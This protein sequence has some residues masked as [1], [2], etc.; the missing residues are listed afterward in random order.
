MRWEGVL[1][2]NPCEG[3]RYKSHTSRI[4]QHDEVT[5][6][7][8]LKLPDRTTFAGLRD[9]TIILTMLD[10]GIRPS[11]LLQVKMNDIDLLNNQVIVGETYSK[12]RQLRTLPLSATVVQAI[13]KLMAA[14]HPDWKKE[15]PVFCT[16]SGNPFSSHN[17]QG[18]FREYSSKI[19]V[20]ITPYHLRHTWFIRNNGNIFALQKIMGHAKLD[21]TRNYVNLIHAD[22][23]NS[24]EAASPINNII[25]TS[26]RVSNIK[27]S[28]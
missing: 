17:L 23:K 6:K 26:K 9:Y 19:G 10:T 24:H 5:I 3:L 4:V 22:V 7:A 2:T 12:T 20:N 18:K 1:K 15:T 11:E 28:K 21:M 13:K 14:R 16:F 27:K 8:F 25:A